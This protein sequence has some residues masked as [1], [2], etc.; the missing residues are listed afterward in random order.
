[1][2][3]F[4]AMNVTQ[5][6]IAL[7]LNVSA[8]LVSRALAGT[9]EEIGASPETIRR[10]REEAGKLN[11][12]PSAAA[13]AL[14]GMPTKTIGLV[15]K[16]FD[17]PFFGH[18]VREFQRLARGQGYSL[19]MTGCDS[20]DVPSMDM[21]SLMK[22]EPDGLVLC[23]SD[24]EP[25]GLEVFIGHG[26]PVVQLGM[27]AKRKGI[28]TVSMD[29]ARGMELLVDHL[30]KF[31][32]EDIGYIGD[33]NESNLRRESV[34]ADVMKRHG[35]KIRKEWFLRVDGA[36]AGYSGM[37]QL[38]ALGSKALPTALVLADDVF[39]IAALR[40]CHEAGLRVPADISLAGVDDIPF[41]HMAIPALTTVRQ[42]IEEMAKAAFEMLVSNGQNGKRTDLV[43]EPRLVIRESCG[44]RKQ[45]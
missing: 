28:V 45:G 34:L 13:L 44:Q 26:L 18:M 1:M 29:Q 25:G 23:G 32:H 11:Y 31:G 20:K 6:D 27:G 12:R 5:K 33:S 36:D 9:A 38:L 21:V 8:S 2:A 17:D 10:I 42:P 15:I 41:A 35:L 40:A 22:Y 14:R 37:K 19:I 16:D 39:A 43:V 3:G 30:L 4:Y 24:F 7:R